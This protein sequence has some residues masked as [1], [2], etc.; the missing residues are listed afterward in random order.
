M[1]TNGYTRDF[2]VL[3]DI[4]GDGRGDYGRV[5][6]DGNV[7]FWRNGG[8]G[9]APSYWQALGTT[10][11]TQ[12]YVGTDTEG[13][14]AGTRFEDINGD[15]RDDMVWLDQVGAG[16]MWTNSRSCGKGLEGDG[17][18]V[19]WREGYLSGHTN[20]QAYAGMGGYVTD[21]ETLL[22]DRI[23]FARIYG[24]ENIFGNLPR[25]DYVFM[26]HT[27]LDILGT[28][29]HYYDVKVWK[30]DGGGGTK[31]KGD[32]NKYCN[33]MGHSN[34]MVDYVWTQSTGAM[35]LWANRGKGTIS[36]SDADGYWEYQ[37][38]M[39]T[40]ESNMN[41]KY[42][43]LADWDGDGDCDIIYA[44]PD[45][46]VEVWINNYPTTGTWDSWSRESWSGLTCDEEPG[47]GIFDLSV[48]FAD[49][50]G[51]GMADHLCIS[52]D[53]AVHGHIRVNTD[54]FTEYLQIK[55]ALDKDRA[56]LRWADVNGDG[57]DDLLW[58]EKFSGDT[59]V[60]YNDGAKDPDDA[61]GSYF[62]WRVQDAVAYAGQVAGSCEYFADLNGDGFADEHYLSLGTFNN[63]ART[64][65]SPG[66]GALK[67]YVGDDSDMTSDLPLPTV[68]GSTTGSGSG[69]STGTG[70]IAGSGSGD[71]AAI[72]EF[73][74]AIGYCPDPCSCTATGTY[75]AGEEDTSVDGYANTGYDASTWTPLCNF[76]CSHNFCPVD[77]CGWDES[78]DPSVGGSIDA[79]PTLDEYLENADAA[80]GEFY[81]YQVPED[82]NTSIS[83]LYNGDKIDV[84]DGNTCNDITTGD[85]GVFVGCVGDTAE[86]L[87]LS[88]SQ[89]STAMTYARR[90]TLDSTHTFVPLPHFAAD[91]DCS[92]HCQLG[93]RANLNEWTPMGEGTMNGRAHSLH[94][95]DT[96][97]TIAFKAVTGS[98]KTA[99]GLTRRVD[100]TTIGAV[101]MFGGLGYE[102]DYVSRSC[103]LVLS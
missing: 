51:N 39:W 3:A 32:G 95:M 30:N 45:A 71:Y 97:K 89:D 40:P 19:A 59:Y 47:L 62:G 34:G 44:A 4:D 70:C 80:A 94:F 100:G 75:D 74:C 24:E 53:S 31:V 7:R 43:H 35:Q 18:F 20:T 21:T 88:I 11:P 22:R 12:N 86:W 66:C 10:W 56:N 13:T 101:A 28:T 102:A 98:L 23:H 54:G 52:P 103:S 15:G 90:A 85:N 5:D 8:T 37:T 99:D 9:D 67:D 87:F 96:G 65:L 92:V 33:M 49:I 64:S 73:T 41:R 6:Y 81:R 17:L 93:A 61:A 78:I 1:A 48:R 57:A 76:A 79:L 55:V 2:V 26:E 60:W 29:N 68:P 91:A 42:L 77:P 25:Q 58:I 46:G 36:D 82:P 16:H 38:V 50:S 83:I 14:Y 72:C 63:E 84:L 69:S 27:T